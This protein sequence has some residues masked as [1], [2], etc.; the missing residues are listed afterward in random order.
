MDNSPCPHAQAVLLSWGMYPA[1]RGIA[2][3]A[4]PSTPLGLA[5]SLRTCPS[6]P[7]LARLGVLTAEGALL[8]RLDGGALPAARLVDVQVRGG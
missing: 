6:P 7:E 1:F 2:V 5:P 4:D 8:R 3:G